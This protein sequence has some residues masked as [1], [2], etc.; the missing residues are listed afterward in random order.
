MSFL[1]EELPNIY[2]CPYQGCTAVYRATDGLKVRPHT[3]LQCKNR[4]P[5]Y[6]IP[7][8]SRTT[9][10]S[11]VLIILFSYQY[12]FQK[13]IKEQHEENRERPCPYPGCNKIFMIDRYLQRHVK[14]IHTGELGPLS[15]LPSWYHLLCNVV[16]FTQ[17][18]YAFTVT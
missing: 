9:E 17:T 5:C 8:Q 12:G 16:A 15:P 14:L 7:Q 13:H 3:C 1:S 6:N 10:I 18:Q 2:K 4:F 11:A